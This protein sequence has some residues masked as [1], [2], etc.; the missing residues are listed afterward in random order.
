MKGTNEILEKIVEESIRNVLCVDDGLL[1]PYEKS[2]GDEMVFEFSKDLYRGIS[3]NCRC[4]V[5]MM[6][7]SKETYEVNLNERLTDKDMLVLDWELD[8]T[9]NIKTPLNVIYQALENCIPYICIYTNSNNLTEISKSIEMYFSGY[10]EQEVKNKVERWESE[11]IMKDV[12]LD[13][14]NLLYEDK[15]KFPEIMKKVREYC[16]DIDCN[17]CEYNKIEQWFLLYLKWNNYLLPDEVKYRAVR[18]ENGENMLN[19]DG[20]MVFVFSKKH[21]ETNSPNSISPELIIPTIAKYITCNPNSIMSCIWLYF[22]NCYAEAVGRRPQYFKDISYFGFLYYIG[23]MLTSG[24]NSLETFL[25]ELF[26]DEL[27]DIMN[28]LKIEIPEEIISKIKKD[29]ES[30]FNNDNNFKELVKINERITINKRYSSCEHKIDFGD[31]F[32]CENAESN[33]CEYWMC[34]SAKC[35]CARPE[36]KIQNNYIFIGGKYVTDKHALKEAE[37][38]FFSFIH[39]TD[40]SKENPI[41]I[42]WCKKINSILIQENLVKVST[43]ISGNIRGKERR[44]T[45]LGNVKENFAQRM[46]N[47]AYSYGNRVGVSLVNLK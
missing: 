23:G 12:F 36:Q 9:N 21:K 15:S 25:K 46:A 45:Y 16:P 11:G 27:L 34:I 5:T 19:I 1:E 14:T 17:K 33:L 6:Q 41:C 38:G 39:T 47:E 44:F 29:F 22:S 43:T 20:R 13:E 28:S 32:Y 8:E 7:Y 18:V 35:D 24:D 4:C 31:V 30:G 42:E 3:D 37:R 40:K 2:E 26:N 10:D